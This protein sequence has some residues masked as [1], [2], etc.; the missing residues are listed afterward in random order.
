MILHWPIP[1]TALTVTGVT[2]LGTHNLTQAYDADR[3]TF[4]WHGGSSPHAPYVFML[5]FHSLVGL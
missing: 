3:V 1:V 4:P 2:V 5:F